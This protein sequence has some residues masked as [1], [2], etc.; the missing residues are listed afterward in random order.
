MAIS[1]SYFPAWRLFGASACAS[2]KMLFQGL[3]KDQR[4]VQGLGSMLWLFAFCG[5]ILVVSLLM[6][7]K[8]KN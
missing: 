1:N 2:R 4:P 6:T 5:S 3:L 7:A 8:E